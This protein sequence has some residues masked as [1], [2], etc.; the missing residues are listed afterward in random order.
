M[1]GCYNVITDEMKQSFKVNIL[2]DQFAA[3]CSTD[4]RNNIHILHSLSRISD[5]R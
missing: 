5:P 2:Q 4:A 3:L 1:A